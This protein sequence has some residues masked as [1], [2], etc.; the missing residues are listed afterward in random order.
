MVLRQTG[1]PPTGSHATRYREISFFPLTPFFL[2]PYFLSVGCFRLFLVPGFT[3]APLNIRLRCLN[4]N[5]GRSCRGAAQH[6]QPTHA[7]GWYVVHHVEGV[8]GGGGELA[9]RLLSLGRGRGGSAYN[10]LGGGGGVD[11][12]PTITWPM[13]KN[14]RT[15]PDKIKGRLKGGRLSNLT[16]ALTRTP[17]HRNTKS[18]TPTTPLP[19]GHGRGTVIG[20]LG[21]KLHSGTRS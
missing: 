17:G 13:T 7:F 8:L 19:T 1:G 9:L 6:A 4:P 21:R 2:S 11:P 14:S 16:P 20:N 5:H 15:P 12:L 18:P 10:H 3:P